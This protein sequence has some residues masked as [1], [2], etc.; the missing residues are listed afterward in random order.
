MRRR[1]R[2]KNRCTFLVSERT[3]WDRRLFV[4]ADER[5]LIGH[6]GVV[7]LHASRTVSD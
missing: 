4:A 3:G 2:C 1:I 6:A 7:L 5:G